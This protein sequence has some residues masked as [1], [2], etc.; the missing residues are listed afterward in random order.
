VEPRPWIRLIIWVSALVLGGLG[1]VVLIYSI[2][3]SANFASGFA[4]IVLAVAAIVY[5]VVVTVSY[6]RSSRVGNSRWYD[7]ERRGF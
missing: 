4:A 7:R 6:A 2:I 1:V 3:G 5:M